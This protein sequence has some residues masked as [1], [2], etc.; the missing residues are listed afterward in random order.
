M[1]RICDTTN[2]I[3]E[4]NR[5][6]NC[7]TRHPLVSIIDMS[8]NG[9]S[10][11]IATDCYAVKLVDGCCKAGDDGHHYYDFSEA[12]MTFATPAKEI[13]LDHCNG[14]MLIFHPHIIKCTPLGI[15]IKDFSFFKYRSDE[16]LYLSCCELKVINRCFDG[17]DCELK[18]GVDEYS[19]PII[20]NCIELLLNYS[21]RF[22]KRQFITRHEANAAAMKTVDGIIDSFLRSGK[23]AEQGMLTAGKIAP[24]LNMSAEYLNDMVKHETGKSVSEYIQLKRILTAKELLLATD[25]PIGSISHMLGFC[26]EGCFSTVF[27]KITGCTPDEYRNG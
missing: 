1:R 18:W 5:V 2:Y 14:K 4:C 11:N 23:A 16:A 24:G 7:E 27:K 12:T 25:M 15:R 19:K 13:C 20:S 3:C 22:Y 26:A 9:S 21:Q 17:I 10:Q 6:F 8:G